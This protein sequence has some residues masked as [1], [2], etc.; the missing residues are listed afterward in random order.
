MLARCFTADPSAVVD[1]W[2]E[3]A[4]QP[5]LDLRDTIAAHNMSV[6]AGNAGWRD[7]SRR[8][9]ADADG[10]AAAAQQLRPGLRAGLP[11][12][13]ARAAAAERP[14]EPGRAA[15]GPAH[16]R[17]RRWAAAERARCAYYC[18]ITPMRSW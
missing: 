12:A 14:G 5:L 3:L 1:V 17:F 18:Y 15:G 4:R 2:L 7:A 6:F 13:A 10:R 11:A 8:R 16:E 9:Q